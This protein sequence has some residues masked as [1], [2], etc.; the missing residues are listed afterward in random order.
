MGKNP[1]DSEDFNNL[2]PKLTLKLKSRPIKIKMPYPRPD[3]LKNLNLKNKKLVHKTT[4][5]LGL[6]S[7]QVTNVLYN[8]RSELYLRVPKAKYE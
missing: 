5:N 3:K 6:Y 7:Q 4:S 2:I 8:N 1:P